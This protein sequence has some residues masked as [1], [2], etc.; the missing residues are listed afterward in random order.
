[1]PFS[2]SMPPQ[3]PPYSECKTDSLHGWEIMRLA[4]QNNYLK[5]VINNTFLEVIY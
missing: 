1:M 4:Y 3:H 5:I 2:Q